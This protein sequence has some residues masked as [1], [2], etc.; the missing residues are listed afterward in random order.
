VRHRQYLGRYQRIRARH[1]S[2]DDVQV[3]FGLLTAKSA[4][5]EA[6]FLPAGL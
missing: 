4:K 6:E 2:A 3:V 1:Q 5:K